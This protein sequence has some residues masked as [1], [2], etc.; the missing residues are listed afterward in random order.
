MNK[1]CN[2]WLKYADISVYLYLRIFLAFQHIIPRGVQSGFIFSH[3]FSNFRNFCQSILIRISTETV[4]SYLQITFQSLAH[5]IF[6]SIFLENIQIKVSSIVSL[7]C[8]T[9]VEGI[10]VEFEVAFIIFWWP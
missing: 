6:L 10:R 2:F 1:G 9:S 7:S 8:S 3:H 5:R 4:N